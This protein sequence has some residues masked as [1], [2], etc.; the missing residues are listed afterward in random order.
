MSSKV[1]IPL[2]LW[3]QL[4]RTLKERGEG[5]RESG[6]FLLGQENSNRVKT[7]ICYDDLD[8]RALQSGII[9]LHSNGFLELWGRCQKERLRVLAD[10]H[11]HPSSWVQQSE[12]DRTHPMVAQKGHFALI[13]PN[14]AK[15]PRRNLTGIGIYEYLGDHTWQTH[16][17]KK[18]PVKITFL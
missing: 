5:E 13:V 11:T 1:K 4:I 15:K 2:L 16:T 7:F 18:S 17:P 3:K 10:V 9:T 14:F 6:A 8:E 12:S